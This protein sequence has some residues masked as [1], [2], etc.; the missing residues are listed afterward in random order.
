MRRHLLALIGAIALVAPVLAAGPAQADGPP[1]APGVPTAI[2]GFQ[3]G[4]ML[5]NWSPP[6]P[7]GGII[8]YQVQYSSNDGADWSDPINTRSAGNSYTVAGLDVRQYYVFQVR[9]YNGG[10]TSAPDSWGPW[11]LKNA[12]PVQPAQ[13]VGPPSYIVTS[14]GNAS[15]SLSWD[16]PS[17]GAKQY[18]VQYSTSRNGPWQPPNNTLST[19][20]DHIEIGGLTPGTTYYF[21]VRSFNSD[22]DKSEWVPAPDPATPTG[23]PNAP[24]NV[25]AVADNAKATVYWTQPTPTPDRYLVQ[26]RTAGG[27]APWVS[28]PNA[29]G[30]STTVTGLTNGTSYVF[31]VAA[32]KDGQQSAWVASNAVTPHPPSTPQAPTS[33]SAYGTDSAAVISWTMPTGQPVTTYLIQYSLNNSQWF[34]ATPVSTGRTDQTFILGGLAN[35]QAYSI[36]VAAANGSLASAYTQM[37][38]TVT[39]VSVPGPPQL[40]T[41]TAGNGSVTLTWKAPII[42][43]PTSPV[44]GYRVQYSSN[45]GSTWVSAPD[46]S[47]P[48]TNTIVNGLAN[49]T[50]YTFR[51]KATSYAGD[52]PWSATTGIITPPG[53]PNPPTN[54]TAVAGNG[55]ATVGWTAPGG[56]SSPVIGYRV[57]AAPG[58]QTCTTSAVPP[59]T[60]ATTCTVTGLTNGQA[61]TFTVVAVTGS[62]TSASSVPSPAVTPSGPSVSIRVTSSGRDGRQVFAK[63]AT[64][65]L[66]SG[67]TVTALVRYK[68]GAAFKP[69]GQV[70]VADDGT[71]SWS[72]TTGKKVWVRFTGGAVTSNTV[73]IGAR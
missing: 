11:S 60:P 23:N 16:E 71:F 19:P 54:V 62:G 30:S 3:R 31:Q 28:A 68:A 61:Y 39:P 10:S 59:T 5:L 41:G 45:N 51:V 50:G 47:A 12:T 38:G 8:G 35:G 42:V 70:A 52:G 15:A 37:P 40:L 73:I 9:A 48:A 56:S 24:T 69:A 63:G 44:T 1:G 67:T 14:S 66:T 25:Q 33:V 36:R 32:V 4:E 49:G 20:L 2:P 34:P 65:G 43:G 27:T 53:G 58:G 17:V 72:T 6:D 57:T 29:T 21:Q 22:A 55:Q 26:Y 18:Q 13:S 7:S 64:Q 46:V